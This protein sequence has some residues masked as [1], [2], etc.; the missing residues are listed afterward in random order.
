MS[1]YPSMVFASDLKAD[2]R[3]AALLLDRIDP[4]RIEPVVVVSTDPTHNVEVETAR[5]YLSP[6]RRAL[7]GPGDVPTGSRYWLAVGLRGGKTTIALPVSVPKDV[8]PLD[9]AGLRLMRLA[10]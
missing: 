3:S 1:L 4:Y 2:W 7:E 8:Q 9:L 10:R 6:G 5:Y